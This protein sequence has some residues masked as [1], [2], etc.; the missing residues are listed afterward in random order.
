L[1][2]VEGRYKLKIR[3]EELEQW[4]VRRLAMED[5][6]FSFGKATV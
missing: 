4:Q 1:G 6:F 3:S 5:L 2:L